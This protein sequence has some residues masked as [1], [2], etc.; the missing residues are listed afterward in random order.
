MPG[1]GLTDL[2]AKLTGL[3]TA[4]KRL[5][6]GRVSFYVYA[7]RGG[8]LVCRTEGTDLDEARG[9]AE[10]IMG[11]PDMLRLVQG[12]QKPEPKVEQSKAYVSGLVTAY[13]ASPE[14]AKRSE[15]LKTAYNHYLESFRAEFG[16]WRV[17]LFEKPETVQDVADWRDQWADRPR[18]ADYALSAVSRLFSWARGKGLT[19]AKPT[20]DIERLHDAEA[21]D[22]SDIIWSPEQVKA[23]CDGASP[24][25]QW[26][27]KLAAYTGLRL[28]DLV[29]LPWSEVT[30]IAIV[31]RTG[32][33]RKKRQVIIPIR[34]ALRD[35]LK[36]IPH[37]A[38]TVLTNSY[39]EA[40]TADGLKTSFR[41]RQAKAKITGLRFHDLRGTA[42]TNLRLAGSPDHDIA[43]ILGWSKEQV[44]AL[45]VRYV[46][47]E[48]VA[49]DMLER[50]KHE[51][52]SS[53]RSQTGK[54]G[55]KKS[56]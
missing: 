9:E 37:R 15:A 35:L 39:G 4:T 13:L 41:K 51:R 18:A 40:W 38:D 12:L 52:P 26:A 49:L 28:G 47:A 50:M 1:P 7:C 10:K 34:G 25:L 23:F 42:A 11:R 33:S 17:S 19:S 22:R 44:Q 53:N 56:Q 27:I 3:H 32:K 5:A 54:R 55:G 29:A 16:T 45:L 30:D 24:E 21:A 20:A 14:L 6:S 36:E 31:T 8:E 46:S 2:R 43:T 48:A